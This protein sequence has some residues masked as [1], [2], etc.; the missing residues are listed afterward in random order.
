MKYKTIGI[1]GGMGPEAT[2]ELYL[3][4]IRIF[5]QQFGAKYDDDFPEIIIV[6]L[7]IPDVV[8]IIDNME[9]EQMLIAGVKKLENAGADFI[10]IPCN[11]INYFFSQM[12]NAVR[13]PILNLLQKTAAEVI[14]NKFQ[15]IGILATEMTIQTNIYGA[16]L[17]EVQL[18][19]PE[20]KKQKAITNIIMNILAGNKYQADIDFLQELIAR[21]KNIG[22]EKIILGCTELPLLIKNADAIDT[23]DILAKAIV[24]EACKK[25]FSGEEND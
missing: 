24:K 2:A 20:I 21:F 15:K 13:I 7:P 22:C 18:L 17:K 6:N 5:Q 9:V 10:A 12:Q 4:I 3:R 11:T 16:V 25:E 14:E 23:I 8:E 19:V 1:L